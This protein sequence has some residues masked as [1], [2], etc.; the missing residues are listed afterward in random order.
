MPCGHFRA[1]LRFIG[2]WSDEGE[3]CFWGYGMITI[4]ASCMYFVAGQPDAVAVV[5][6]LVGTLWG[7]NVAWRVLWGVVPSI[8]SRRLRTLLVEEWQIA[9]QQQLLF[10][11][12][13]YRRDLKTSRKYLRR[14]GFSRRVARTS[15]QMNARM[16]RST[17]YSQAQP[18]PWRAAR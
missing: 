11:Y 12:R 6:Q 17:Q 16:R 2:P 18:L 5:M 15:L 10:G 9:G 13:A 4:F 14:A 1:T 3:A 7:I 8:F